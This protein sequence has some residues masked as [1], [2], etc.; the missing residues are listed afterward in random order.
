[1]R[2]M[3]VYALVISDSAARIMHPAEPWREHRTLTE[4]FH[5]HGDMRQ[6]ADLLA[7][8]FSIPAPANPN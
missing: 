2:E 3:R 7:V 8:Q 6:F 4:G 5:F 1:M